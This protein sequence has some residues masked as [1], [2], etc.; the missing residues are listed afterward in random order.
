M[1]ESYSGPRGVPI[2]QRLQM[3][4]D[5]CKL[6][7]LLLARILSPAN[8]GRS[9]ARAANDSLFR[10]LSSR[11]WDI[12]TFTHL[13]DPTGSTYVKWAQKNKLEVLSDDV[14]F[15]G[16]LHWVGPRRYDRVL[17]YFHGGGYSFP[18]SDQSQLAF[19]LALQRDLGKSGGAGIAFLEYSLTPYHPFPTQLNQ[20]NAAISHLLEKGLSPSKLIL[21]GDS[22]G[23]NLVFQVLSNALHPFLSASAPPTISAPY[24][25]ALLISPWFAFDP[26]PSFAE[27]DDKD[28]V[29]AAFWTF[30]AEQ[31]TSGLPAGARVYAEPYAAD[32]AWWDGLDRLVVRVF[33]TAGEVECQRDA[34]VELLGGPVKARV[35]DTTVVVEKNGVHE[36]VLNAFACGE[37]EK[38]AEYWMMVKW[39]M[40][41]FDK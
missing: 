22:A 5:F 37:G 35:S 14:G 40:E 18:V 24:G 2:T 23:G 26:V 39:A 3:T 33:A 15:G 28:L 25:G 1:S 10:F 31:V 30:L 41:V 17:L 27:N 6:P 7:F 11:Q 12:H 21:S 29:P 20:A 38:S 36:D 13:F 32:A 34:I 16:K 4:L 19:L 8:K 9:W